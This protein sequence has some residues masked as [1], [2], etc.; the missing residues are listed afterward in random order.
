[1]NEEQW[2][3]YTDKGKLK[4]MEKNNF[5]YGWYLDGWEQSNAGM[6]LTGEN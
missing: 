3:N 6:L 5:E 4:Y 2:S 1:M